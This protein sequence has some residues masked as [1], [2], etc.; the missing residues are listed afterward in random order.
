[1][2]DF[3]KGVKKVGGGVDKGAKITVKDTAK[4]VETVGSDTKKGAEYMGKETEKEF[5]PSPPIKK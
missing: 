4:G 2:K 5:L 1:M 3:G